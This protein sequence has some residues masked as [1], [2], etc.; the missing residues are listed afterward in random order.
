MARTTKLVLLSAAAMI[1][2]GGCGGAAGDLI[3]I[4]VSGG[5]E[6][7]AVEVTVTGDGR[8]RCARGPLESLSGELLLD[9]RELE[10]ALSPLAAAARSFGSAGG[11]RRV[12]SARMV[13]GAV[14]WVEGAPDLPPVL[15]NAVILQRALEREICG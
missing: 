9:A 8:A 2:L 12:Y 3:A 1:A 5:F 13:A 10:R 4:E 15:G 11:D 6:P 7:R 14:R